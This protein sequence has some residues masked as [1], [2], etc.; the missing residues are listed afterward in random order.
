MLI[1]LEG[2]DG[3]GKTTLARKL[4]SMLRPNPGH[5][6]TVIR[7]RVPIAHPLGE[8][9]L[10]ILNY[11]PEC[12]EH[13]I[14]DR[15]HWG[16]IVYPAILGRD[17]QLDDV[18][19]WHIEATLKRRGALVVHCSA[20]PQILAERV[21][22]RGDDLITPDQCGLI[23]SAFYHAQGHSTLPRVHGSTEPEQILNLAEQLELLYAPL[24][25]FTTYVGPL[26]PRYLL[27]GDIRH[28][29]SHPG[30]LRP[31]FMPYPATSGHYLIKSIPEQMLPQC[32]IANA[33]DADNVV[34]LWKTLGNPQIVTLGRNAQRR[35]LDLGL[36]GGTVPHPQ[37][38]RRFYHAEHKQY[39]DMILDAA[40]HQREVLATWTQS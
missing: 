5:S 28:N 12:G 6:T 31:A 23:H 36:P 30:D 3:A 35:C 14:C 39:G 37:F 21:K 26:A 27:L 2:P 25:S 16:E 1:I 32:G 22:T 15:W 13:I 34:E 20:A 10:P 29:P 18:S 38:V 19:W 40:R 7:K 4:Q 8:Y 17:T 24:A 9:E 33:C 11:R